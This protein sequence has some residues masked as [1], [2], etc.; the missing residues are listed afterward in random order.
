[1]KFTYNVL[2]NL[3]YVFTSL[4]LATFFSGC[5]YLNLDG[6]SSFDR[7]INSMVVSSYQKLK[8]NLE[9]DDVI[10]VSDF[11]NIDKLQNHS[12]LG[13]L[14]SETLKDVLSNQNI[15]IR[16]VE[17]GYNFKI[18]EKGF[19]VLSRNAND[20]D[21]DI[22]KERFAVVG[23]YAITDKRLRIF[24][25]LIDIQTGHILSSAS[26]STMMTDEIEKL[27]VVPKQNRQNSVYAPMVL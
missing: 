25:K 26:E 13:F 7:L 4:F 6:S 20:I 5:I 14:L 16:E 8:M 11:V 19:T 21:T 9:Q 3:K 10:L 15:I 23:T 2:K 1:M 24:I 17:L 27:E 18:G 12:K 22:T